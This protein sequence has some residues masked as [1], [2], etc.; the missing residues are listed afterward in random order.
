MA[1]PLF[2]HILADY[3]PDA[4]ENTLYTSL[5]CRLFPDS[6]VIV[7]NQ[8]FKAGDVLGPG[9]FLRLLLTDYPEETVHICMLHP[10]SKAGEES[11]LL[12]RTGKTVF[13]APDNGLLP[14]ALDNSEVEYFKIPFN[15]P[16]KDT[17]KQVY[18]PAL[19][20]SFRAEPPALEIIE[21]PRKQLIPLPAISNNSYRLTV[22]YNDSHGNAYMNMDK[23]EFERITAGKQFAIRL[24]MRDEIT[25]I[26]ENYNDVAPSNKLALFGLGNLLQIAVNCGSAAQYHG[27]KTHQQIIMSVL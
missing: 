5:V 3:G 24:G 22:L 7:S 20:A 13:L 11:Y 21:S 16:N 2:I 1:H 6:K 17:M 23:A 10:G 18:L 15:T 14:I 27:L 9:I 19:E 12:A 8:V 25:K 4:I 26:S